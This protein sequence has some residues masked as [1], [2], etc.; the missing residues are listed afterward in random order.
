MFAGPVGEISII[1]EIILAAAFFWPITLLAI[2]SFVGFVITGWW[3]ILEKAEERGWVS[4]L[5]LY[6]IWVLMKVAGHGLLMRSVTMFL[7]LYYVLPLSLSD[8]GVI[9]EQI[10]YQTFKWINLVL[11][12][13]FGL[14]LL[15]IFYYT[16][17]LM[18]RRFDKSGW[19]ATGL[20]LLPF[21]FWPMLGFGDAQYKDSAQSNL[22]KK[23]D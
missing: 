1:G 5:P 4:L 6:N 14:M 12:L 18:A 19:Y 2:L 21:I 20:F 7:I 23:Y 9:Y 10:G 16:C 3:L 17:Y 11:P 22:N 15:L 8:T 13:T